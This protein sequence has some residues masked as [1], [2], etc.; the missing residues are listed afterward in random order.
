M[1]VRQR[2]EWRMIITFMLGRPGRWMVMALAKLGSKKTRGIFLREK[3][4]Q[5]KS[6]V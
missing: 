4:G 1:R 2:K 6:S 3:Q 5:E